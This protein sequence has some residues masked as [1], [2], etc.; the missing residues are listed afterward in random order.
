MRV[1]IIPACGMAVSACCLEFLFTEKMQMSRTREHIVKLLISPTDT[2][3]V[4]KNKRLRN[5]GG[6]GRDD[7]AHAQWGLGGNHGKGEWP[8]SPGARLTSVQAFW[9]HMVA[10]RCI[11][12]IRR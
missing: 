7:G 10:F 8:G 4:H 12:A 2:N 3:I 9:L 5:F 1:H 11:S 6:E